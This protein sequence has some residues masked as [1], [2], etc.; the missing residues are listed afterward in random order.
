[1]HEI[2]RFRDRRPELYGPILNP[3]DHNPSSE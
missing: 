1:M 2:D 3:I